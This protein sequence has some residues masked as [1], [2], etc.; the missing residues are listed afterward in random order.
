[1]FSDHTEITLEINNRNVTGKV[2]KQL[3]IKQDPSS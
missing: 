1:M 2:S 3:D